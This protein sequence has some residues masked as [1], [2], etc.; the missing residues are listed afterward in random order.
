M[1]KK[2][3]SCYNIKYV[4][5]ILKYIQVKLEVTFFSIINKL[6]YKNQEF[7]TWLA[8]WLSTDLQ[9]IIIMEILIVPCL[10][11]AIYSSPSI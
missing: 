11:N 8:V 9:F 6:S 7:Q 10:E 5:L 2:N 3:V 4:M 1:P